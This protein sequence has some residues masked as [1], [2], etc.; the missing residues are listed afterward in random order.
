MEVSRFFIGIIDVLYLIFLFGGVGGVR[1]F[2][3]V[4]RV[5]VELVY[6]FMIRS[7]LCS[8]IFSCEL[9]FLFLVVF[10]IVWVLEIWLMC[11][12]F[13]EYSLVICG[14]GMILGC[15]FEVNGV[16]GVFNI[17]ILLMSRMDVLFIF[18]MVCIF[19]FFLG[20]ILSD[21]VVSV[22]INLDGGLRGF[23]LIR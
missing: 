2:V 1:V 22:R 13:L 19:L 11:I 23:R 21:V 18:R 20:I 9:L 17:V 3:K 5:W 4:I 6:V 10:M 14:V 8:L 7:L 15:C 12:K 16:L